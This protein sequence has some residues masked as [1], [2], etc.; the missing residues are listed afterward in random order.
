MLMLEQ[1]IYMKI[2]FALKYIMGQEAKAKKAENASKSFADRKQRREKTK[3][4]S[5]ISLGRK[6]KAKNV[7]EK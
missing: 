3:N 7:Q 4:A 6:P 2:K 5:N 1:Q